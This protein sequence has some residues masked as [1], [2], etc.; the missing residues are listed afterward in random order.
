MRTVHAGLELTCPGSVATSMSQDVACVEHQRHF[1][2][3][4]Y[5]ALVFT[6]FSIHACLVFLNAAAVYAN[7]VK[8]SPRSPHSV[9]RKY[10][11]RLISTS[12]RR[13]TR[14]GRLSAN[15]TMG[16][17]SYFCRCC[18]TC[19]S[20]NPK[21]YANI[22]ISLGCILRM[23]HLLDPDANSLTFTGKHIYGGSQ[24]GERPASELLYTIPF[25]LSLFSATVLILEWQRVVHST[26][27]I[28]RL[29]NMPRTKIYIFSVVGTI[30]LLFG[31]CFIV[32]VESTDPRNM[33]LKDISQG[34][35]GLYAFLSLIFGT[36]YGCKLRYLLRSVA[37]KVG[38]V[39][40]KHRRQIANLIKITRVVGLLVTAFFAAI[41]GSVL[42]IVLVDECEL[43]VN[44][45]MNRKY[46][47]AWVLPAF[48]EAVGSFAIVYATLPERYFSVNCCLRKRETT[49]NDTSE[50]QLSDRADDNRLTTDMTSTEV[51]TD[52]VN[53][54]LSPRDRPTSINIAPTTEKM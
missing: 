28:Q 13:S 39:S 26:S 50:V 22:C 34:I 7:L 33:I 52:V 19:L 21:L 16:I 45:D 37:M 51:S 8:R 44:A 23:L 48:G 42:R 54:S 43:S 15:K 3:H 5:L 2:P 31:L 1:L 49:A 32:F 6:I 14:G 17:L 29:A 25:C 46:L 12:S 20:R 4:T 30:Y 18:H 41:L 24:P 38:R 11:S 53:E 27:S 35:F 36:W 10:S 40:Q 47:L 9:A